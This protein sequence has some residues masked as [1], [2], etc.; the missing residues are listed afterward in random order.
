MSR[1][2]VILAFALLAQTFAKPATNYGNS[3]SSGG[4]STID[5]VDNSKFGDGAFGSGS[6]QQKP[7]QPQQPQ[8]QR[9]C[10][11]VGILLN[12]LLPVC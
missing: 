7:Q 12:P 2:V 9:P 1:F 10:S 4:D 11:L 6:H 3:M 8:T 5:V